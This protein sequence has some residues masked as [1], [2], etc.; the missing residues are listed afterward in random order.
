MLSTESKFLFSHLLCSLK[1]ENV[2]INI[3]GY[4]KITDFGL[5]KENIEGSNKAT[6]FCGTPEYLAPETLLRQG[7]GKAADW[8]SFG[9]I[10]YEMVVGV[11]PFYTQNRHELYESIKTKEINFL[12][13]E[14]L[15]QRK[16]P[17]DLKDLI[18]KLLVKDPNLRLG[19]GNGDSEEIKAHPFFSKNIP[20]WDDLLNKKY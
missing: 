16:A 17:D 18:S 14:E 5:S 20:N 7:T 12:E 9:C 11:P 13:S 10:V 4:V 8:W 2:L 15:N 3:D 1:P 19:G 6:S